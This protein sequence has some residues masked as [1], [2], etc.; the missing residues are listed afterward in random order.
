MVLKTYWI[1]LVS[2]K[3]INIWPN[4]WPKLAS[5]PIFG[6]TNFWASWVEIFVMGLLS[7]D[8][9]KEIQSTMLD[10]RFWFFGPIL[11]GRW[12]WSPQGNLGPYNPTKKLAQWVAPLGELLFWEPVFKIFRAEPPPSIRLD[13][14]CKN[15]KL[16]PYLSIFTKNYLYLDH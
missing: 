5:M 3:N 7:I 9:L 12:A 14:N 13:F 8:W 15:Q 10:F 1:N 16:S 6:H 11:A 4:D 2:L